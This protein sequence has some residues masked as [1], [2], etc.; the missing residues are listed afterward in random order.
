MHGLKHLPVPA[1]SDDDIGMLRRGIAV[2]GN[3]RAAR[4]FGFLHLARHK[5]DGL[6]PGHGGFD[7]WSM[8]TERAL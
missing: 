4:V 1:Q 7:T 6:E 5:G 8:T 3:Q 2:A